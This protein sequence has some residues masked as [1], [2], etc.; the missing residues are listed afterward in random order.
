[1]EG[2][3]EQGCS[4]DEHGARW[5]SN[6]GRAG[7]WGR[8]EVSPAMEMLARRSYDL[9]SGSRWR[10]W[11]G[12]VKRGL[13][14]VWWL[15]VSMA[16]IS[17]SPANTRHDMNPSHS[18]PAQSH[19]LPLPVPPHGQAVLQGAIHQTPVPS[20]PSSNQQ[21]PTMCFFLFL[22]SRIRQAFFSGR[23]YLGKWFRGPQPRRRSM[24]KERYGFFYACPAGRNLEVRYCVMES[25][26]VYL[27]I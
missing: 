24:Y 7:S 9:S 23:W 3:R 22:I 21:L 25:H 11:D 2:E 17:Q 27:A 1:M 26:R 19:G 16:K 20:K 10:H 14:D 15:P 13:S 4:G 5:H 6:Q 18:W 8:L 12:G